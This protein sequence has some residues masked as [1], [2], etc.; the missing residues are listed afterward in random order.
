MVEH[1]IEATVAGMLDG[2][3]LRLLC[4]FGDN[5]PVV[6]TFED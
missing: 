5:S 3:R 6:S 2:R 1:P 4:A